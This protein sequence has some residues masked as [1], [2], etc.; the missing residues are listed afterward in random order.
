MENELFYQ[1]CDELGLLVI[2]DMPALRPL[3]STTNPSTCVSTTIL[4]DPQQQAEFSR[5]LEL[6]VNQHKSFPS[7]AT[8]VCNPL[9]LNGNKLPLTNRA[10]QIIYNEG[11]GQITSYYPEFGLTAMVK[12]LDPTRLVDSTTGWF[13]HG[14]GDF[15]VRFPL[16]KKTIRRNLTD[17]ILG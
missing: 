5:Q 4:P 7:I 13:D 2:Q 1:A 8:W 17:R 14:A 12:Q 6:L 16:C 10:Y 11:W 3:Q 15:S 9:S